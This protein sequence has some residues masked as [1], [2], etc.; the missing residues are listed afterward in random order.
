M[1]FL[2]LKNFPND[3]NEPDL[4]NFVPL[5]T[6]HQR[7]KKNIWNFAIFYF[8]YFLRRQN[9]ECDNT[10]KRKLTCAQQ[11]RCRYAPS[12]GDV[13]RIKWPKCEIYINVWQYFA[14]RTNESTEQPN[15]RTNLNSR[16]L[17]RS[18]HSGAAFEFDEWKFFFRFCFVSSISKHMVFNIW[19][20][21][22][23]R[24]HTSR[25]KRK[26][27]SQQSLDR[28]VWARV[29]SFTLTRNVFCHQQYTT[30]WIHSN[31]AFDGGVVGVFSL[32]CD[33]FWLK[34]Q[35]IL[36]VSIRARTVPKGRGVQKEI[37]AH[38][39]NKLKN[40][41]I[42]FDQMGFLF[43]KTEIYY[44]IYEWW[45]YKMDLL[46]IEWSFSLLS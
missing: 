35:R 28:N 19:R 9:S 13:W 33:T 1:L 23:D 34:Y 21:Q 14:Q 22:N 17:N 37:E 18:T 30:K 3:Q 39:K 41:R 8:W 40:V 6:K 27:D 31:I 42:N 29:H 24:Q 43:E 11:I 15:E 20:M 12:T 5:Q 7:K 44:L 26:I 32:L 25:A 45:K 36:C 16:T 38:T 10:N 2:A 46:K 4:L